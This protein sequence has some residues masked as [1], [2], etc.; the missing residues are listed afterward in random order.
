MKDI[1]ERYVCTTDSADILFLGFTGIV[2][3]AND[4]QNCLQLFIFIS[5]LA[6]AITNWSATMLGT[7]TYTVQAPNQRLNGTA[8]QAPIA[9]ALL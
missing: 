1:F 3:L 8:W 5:P 2:N 4:I 7:L 9:T 6:S